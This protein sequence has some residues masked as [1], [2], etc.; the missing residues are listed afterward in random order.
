[1]ADSKSTA[2]TNT[3]LPLDA[4][5]AEKFSLDQS[6]WRTL[7]ETIFPA[8]KSVEAVIMALD[9]CKARNLDIMKRPVHIVP[10]YSAERQ[11]MVETVWPG[12]SELRTTAMRTGKF[13]GV[14]DTKWGPD[15]TKTFKGKETYWENKQKLTRDVEIELTFPEWA[16]IHVFRMI[17]NERVL[18]AGPIVYWE[19]TYA[20]AGRWSEAPNHM[21]SQ[22]PRGQ[23]EKCAEAAAL[24]RAFPEEFGGEYAAEEMAGQI[25]EG[26][27]P[28]IDHEET[29]TKVPKRT[30]EKEEPVDAGQSYNEG[31][32]ARQEGQ[33]LSECPDTLS[34]Q[35]YKQWQKGWADADKELTEEPPE[36]PKGEP[37]E[38]SLDKR[39]LDKIHSDGITERQLLAIEED[40]KAFPGKYGSPKELK[41]VVAQR[42]LEVSAIEAR[43]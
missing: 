20:K 12:I 22:R 10:M 16:Q 34:T 5:I 27:G 14:A 13:A 2:L 30:V 37:E 36:E 1:M 31:Y 33:D 11:G 38:E 17:G 9:Y 6:R 25:L 23:L 3:R 41:E 26:N 4:R 8:A 19:E 24:R 32:Q 21:W 7:T 40:L 18:W 15:V 39:V 35:Q 28:I 43:A 42:I 29:P